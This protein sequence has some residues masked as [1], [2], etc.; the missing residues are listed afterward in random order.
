MQARRAFNAR[1]NGIRELAH[2][3]GFLLSDLEVL[4]HGHGVQSADPW[5]IM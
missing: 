2:R 3:R 1:N 4:F 5:I